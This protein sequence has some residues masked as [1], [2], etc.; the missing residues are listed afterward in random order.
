MEMLNAGMYAQ[1]SEKYQKRMSN[2]PRSLFFHGLSDPGFLTN[3]E[4][5]GNI[6]AHS[7]FGDDKQNI[8]KILFV[9]L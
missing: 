6:V 9:S 1:D 5:V 4:N 3:P 8:S 7:M 2:L